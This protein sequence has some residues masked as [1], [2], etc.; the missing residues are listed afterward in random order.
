MAGL[1]KEGH[2]VLALI[3]RGLGEV[4]P[5][6]KAVK[7]GLSTAHERR[8]HDALAIGRPLLGQRVLDVLA[9]VDVLAAWGCRNIGV[10]GEGAG[11]L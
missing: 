11:G 10:A 5:N 2:T 7:F 4:P 8:V 6:E 9:A 1:V 3:T